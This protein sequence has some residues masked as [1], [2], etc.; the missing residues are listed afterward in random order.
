MNQDFG[1]SL[2]PAIARR[3]LRIQEVSNVKL[4][5]DLTILAQ[6]DM[7]DEQSFDQFVCA[8]S[9]EKRAITQFLLDCDLRGIVQRLYHPCFDE[10]AL[11]N[12][13]RLGHPEHI[14]IFT[15]RRDVWKQASKALFLDKVTHLHYHFRLSSEEID[16]YRSGVLIV[17]LQQGEWSKIRDYGAE[18]AKTIIYDHK[19]ADQMSPS[20]LPNPWVFAAHALFPTMPDPMYPRI[21]EDIPEFWRDK[22]I[23][24]FSVYYNMCIFR[25]YVNDRI[26][27]LLDDKWIHLMI[28]QHLHSFQLG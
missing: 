24:L 17:D 26:L 21:I 2:T 10:M 28:Q 20:V 6:Q 19:T 25:E 13:V 18:F 16:K 22:P 15:E 11:L 7:I 8:Y 1:L 27:A 12:A 14:V 3:L 23:H 5:D 9:D 4:P